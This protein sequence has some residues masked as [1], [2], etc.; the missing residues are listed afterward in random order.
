MHK[1]KLP[2]NS[3]YPDFTEGKGVA[4]TSVIPQ[5]NEISEKFKWNLTD[6]YIN[7]AEWE[8]DFNWVE[9][10]IIN[11]DS[12]RGKLN[13]DSES[14]LACFKFDDSIGIKLERMYLYA[15]L[16]KDMDMSVQK[17]LAMD[18]RIKTIYS[19]VSAANSFIHPELLLIL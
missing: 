15:M 13:L 4:D 18:D 3:F 16:S 17:Y 5:R 2:G 7:D 8:K 11:Y 6:I 9:R 19:K 14:L 12:F 10:Y 1:Q